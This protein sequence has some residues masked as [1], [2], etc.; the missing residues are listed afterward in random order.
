[1]KVASENPWAVMD[2]N[3]I[4]REC[5]RVQQSEFVDSFIQSKPATR[6]GNV[7]TIEV[8]AP[9]CSRYEPPPSLD[10][11]EPEWTT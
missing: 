10:Y 4:C 2:M 7:R 5:A 3:M 6:E 11:D 9:N 8:H 1:M